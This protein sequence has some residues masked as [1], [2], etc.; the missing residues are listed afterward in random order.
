M[1]SEI[2]KEH[3]LTMTPHVTPEVT[4]AVASSA[5]LNKKKWGVIAIGVALVAAIV[6]GW[7]VLKPAGP[8]VGFVSG[9][10]RVEATEID[11]ATKLAGRVQN[12]MVDEGDFVHAGQTLA[13]MQID[14]LDAQRDAAQAQ[15]R[16]AVNAVASA[17]AGV[18]AHPRRRSRHSQR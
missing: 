18:V 8:G 2:T 7:I 15:S 3:I 5:L 17:E 14:V 13:Q 12:I 9:N 11:V 4:S 6:V 16:Q 1:E 10:G